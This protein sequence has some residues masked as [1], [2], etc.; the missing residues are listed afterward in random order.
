MRFLKLILLTLGISAGIFASDCD[1]KFTLTTASPTVVINNK[2]LACFVWQVTDFVNGFSAVSVQ[3]ESASDANGT[4]GPFSAFAGTITS[5]SN[6]NTS[7]TQ[8]TTLYQGA[9]PWI[10]MNLVS[11]TGS[12]NVSGRI[13]G[14]QATSAAV[15]FP[16]GSNVG[17]VFSWPTGAFHTPIPA[18]FSWD[19]QDGSVDILSAS[20]IKP[21]GDT[22]LNVTLPGIL[23]TELNVRY[24][25]MGIG[26]PYTYDLFGV[27][28]P[29]T[30][31]SEGSMCIGD[32]TGK[33]ISLYAQI[34]QFTNATTLLQTVSSGVTGGMASPLFLRISDNGVTRSYQ[35][36]FDGETYSEL[37][38]EPSGTFLTATRVGY[39]INSA[40]T[41]QNFIKVFHECLYSGAGVPI[42]TASCL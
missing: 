22:I 41:S 5:G 6:P 38:N 15:G 40:R 11:S 39:C 24:K 17:T 20:G 2:G 12:G 4:P 28:G 34:D 35:E 37:F 21:V 26:T 16:A 1:F 27:S 14:A 7:T 8:N 36:S 30:A 23:G 18:A 32:N 13:L 33:W 9:F 10:R 3:F 29:N 42:G 19:N 31:V 25:A